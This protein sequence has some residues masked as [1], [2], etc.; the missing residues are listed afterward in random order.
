MRQL[1]SA[2][3]GQPLCLSQSDALKYC[4]EQSARYKSAARQHSSLDK[5]FDCNGRPLSDLAIHWDGSQNGGAGEMA[6]D[7]ERGPYA[8]AQHREDEVGER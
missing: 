7:M 5:F 2:V 3:L 1:P 6:S 4:D 8:I